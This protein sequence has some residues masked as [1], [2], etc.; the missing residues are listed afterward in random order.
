[1]PHMAPGPEL[2]GHVEA[3]QGRGA[4]PVLASGVPPTTETLQGLTHQ[5]QEGGVRLF[6]SQ[7]IIERH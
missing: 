2:K 5:H 1:M 4:H 6:T 3:R 7:M